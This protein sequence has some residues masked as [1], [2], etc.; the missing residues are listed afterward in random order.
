M[1]IRHQR[2]SS[3]DRGFR[4]LARYIRGRS[5]KPR[6]TWFLA[7]NLSGVTTSDDLELACRLVEA[8]HAQ[9]TRAGSGEA[10]RGFTNTAK[11]ML[12]TA[13]HER[14]GDRGPFGP[15]ARRDDESNCC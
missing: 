11:R 6:T 10:A 7:A 9:N 15:Q 12:G 13:G 4:Q 14:K 2:A 1:I 5:S 3:S 8:V